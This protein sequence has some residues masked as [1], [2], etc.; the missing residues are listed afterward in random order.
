[1]VKPLIRK[2][3]S[4]GE[5]VYFPSHLPNRERVYHLQNQSELGSNPSTTICSRYMPQLPLLYR[6]PLTHALIQAPPTL[7]LGWP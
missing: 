7:N 3:L 5:F 1:M 4:V 6:A 2:V